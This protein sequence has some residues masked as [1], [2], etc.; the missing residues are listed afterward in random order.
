[1]PVEPAGTLRQS[2]TDREWAV[3]F[4]RPPRRCVR[5]SVCGNVFTI[6][7]GVTVAFARD[8]VGQATMWC[9]YDDSMQPV[10]GFVWATYD[11]VVTTEAV[12][13]GPSNVLKLNGAPVYVNGFTIRM[14]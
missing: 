6:G 10:A 11:G 3:G 5:H 12:T 7:I 8:P 2:L 9:P 14:G 13:T 1:M 4:R